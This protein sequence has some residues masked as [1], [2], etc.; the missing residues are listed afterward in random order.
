VVVNKC[1]LK[2]G[3]PYQR[4]FTGVDHTVYISAKE[5]QH[6]EKIIGILSQTAAIQRLEEEL[7]VTNTRH[8]YALE[9]SLK[10][11]REIEKGLSSSIPTDLVAVDIRTAMHYL[12]E[13]TG[14]ISTQEVLESIF[15]TFC[16]GK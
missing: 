7:I 13:I 10:A 14:D 12:G 15:S 3:I 9:R 4:P 16:I 5:Q 1:D 8:F 11:I 6:L 2:S